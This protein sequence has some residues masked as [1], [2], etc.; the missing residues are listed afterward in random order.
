LI[1]RAEILA[2]ASDLGL[3]AEIVEKDYVLGWLLNGIYSHDALA[4]ADD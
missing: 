4:P 2:I 1:D 3:A